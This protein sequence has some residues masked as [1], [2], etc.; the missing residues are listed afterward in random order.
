MASKGEAMESYVQKIN[1]DTRRAIAELRSQNERLRLQAAAFESD[2]NRLQQEKLRLQDQLITAREALS[3]R[4]DEH[5]ALLRRLS[6]VELENER[7]AAQFLDIETQNTNLANLYVA[8]YQ[9]RSSLK[10]TEIMSAIKEIIVNLI[11]SEDFAIYERPGDED[12]LVP[13]DWFDE[14]TRPHHDVRFGE[15]VIGAVASTGDAYIVNDASARL[16]GMTACIPLKVDG[17]VIG[18]IAV[19]RLLPQKSNAIEALDREL[20]DLLAAQAGIAL[21]CSRLQES[22]IA[23]QTSPSPLTQAHE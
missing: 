8:S 3:D 9:L 17:R 23:N 16:A 21:Y 5:S 7:V 19:Y 10:R 6:E 20:F 15:G 11:G 1:D 18:A 2:R 12:R 14:P 13:V 22:V 4:Q